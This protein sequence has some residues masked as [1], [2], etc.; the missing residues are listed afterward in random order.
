MVGG[1]G[2]RKGCVG[3]LDS[4]M[5]GEEEGLG[6]SKSVFYSFKPLSFFLL[7]GEGEKED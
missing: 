6:K 2:G 4:L 1:G 7:F 5:E 3:R